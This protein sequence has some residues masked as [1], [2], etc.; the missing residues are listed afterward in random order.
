MRHALLAG[1]ALVLFA[2]VGLTAC[3]STQTTAAQTPAPTTTQTVTVVLTDTTI[4][5]TPT[6]F[7]PGVRCHFIVTNHGTIP[8]EFLIMPAGMAQL[9]GQMPMAQWHQQAL[10]TTGMI[11][12]GMM[13]TFDYTF[14][15]MPMM[16][17][18]QY[19]AFGCYADGHPL[20]YVPIIV[21]P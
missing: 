12:P 4:T 2:A 5:A 19:P 14:A 7:R 15:N 17:Q 3:G 20:M 18:E 9:M 8:H 6:T 1:V 16:T 21:Q 10:H 11:G 13:T